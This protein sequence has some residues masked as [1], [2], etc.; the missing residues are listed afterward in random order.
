M[1][2]RYPRLGEVKTRIAAEYGDDAALE[3]HDLLARRTL[4]LLLALQANGEARAEVRCDAAF[5]G[6][7]REWLGKGPAYRYQGDG[8]LGAKL[9][10]AFATAFRGGE[11]R[12]VVVGGDCAA[13]QASHLRAAFSALDTHDCVLGPAEDGGYYLIGLRRSAADRATGALFANMPWGSSEVL[14]QTLNA[15]EHAGI[16]A[17]QLE[18]LP[19][20]D[21]PED[22]EPARRLL[23]ADVPGANARVSVVVPVLNDAVSLGASVASA[24]DGGAREVVVADGGSTDGSREVAREMGATVVDAPRGRA[25]QMNAGAAAA[26][27]DVLCFLHADTVLP[28]GWASAATMALAAPGV[29]ACAFDFSVPRSARHAGLITAAGQAR[30]R[31]TRVPYGDQVV[32]MT[33]GTFDALSG[34]AE[35]PALEDYEAARRLKRLGRVVRVPLAVETSARA[36]EVHGLMVPTAVNLASIIGFRLGVSPEVIA[37][38]R[39]RIAPRSPV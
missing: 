15:A 26:S 22:V 29:S 33:R 3:L 19:D 18:T 6:A 5:N 2:V 21:R 13:L 4:R 39:S 24:L 20:V 31:L 27:G 34:F 28:P 14:A 1:L 17:A 12:A 10:F 7:A 23:A 9:A 38:W 36:W 16:T 32:C 11:E 35:L 8:D 25:S 37:T 30:W